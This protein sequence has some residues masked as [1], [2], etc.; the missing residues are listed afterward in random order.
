[1]F[2]SNGVLL[3]L[4]VNRISDTSI[5]NICSIYGS[6]LSII[7]CKIIE[8]SSWV[9]NHCSIIRRW[10]TLSSCEIGGF[11]VWIC[12]R[13]W[14]K[15]SCLWIT[16]MWAHLIRSSATQSTSFK[17]HFT[18]SIRRHQRRFTNGLQVLLSMPRLY[19]IRRSFRARTPVALPSWAVSGWWL[20]VWSMAF[21]WRGSTKVGV[22]LT[23][24]R[25]FICCDDLQKALI[26]FYIL[27]H[28]I[29]QNTKTIYCIL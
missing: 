2:G 21:T 18:Q 3:I 20:E 27:L 8:V 11:S 5:I 15:L 4:F 1:M 14:I 9:R 10:F 6:I 29:I 26:L 23:C 25:H 16:S 19:P 12:Y 22:F 24:L 17:T 13:S 28:Y 7:L